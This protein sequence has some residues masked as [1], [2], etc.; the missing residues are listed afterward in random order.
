MRVVI[1]I[2]A[3]LFFICLLVE[4]LGGRTISWNISNLAKEGSCQYKTVDEGEKILLLK[5]IEDFQKQ[6]IVLS[7]NPFFEKVKKRD[8][9]ISKEPLPK[10]RKE[11]VHPEMVIC[12]GVIKFP[13][14]LVAVIYTSGE[15]RTFFVKK[16]DSFGK[17]KVLDILQNEIVLCKEGGSEKIYLK[18]GGNSERQE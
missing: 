14:E 12:K 16:G 11:V 4:F 1:F 18:V 13:K 10:E 3:L 5:Q 17:Y 7:Q 2:N 9:D 6:G 8:R 15:K